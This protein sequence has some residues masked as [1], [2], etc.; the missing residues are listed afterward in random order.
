MFHYIGSDRKLR[1]DFSV[2]KYICP[3][4]ILGVNAS[5]NL[6]LLQIHVFQYVVRYGAVVRYRR[7]GRSKEAMEHLDNEHG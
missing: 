4:K 6:A 3:C 7:N 1:N 5:I 2:A